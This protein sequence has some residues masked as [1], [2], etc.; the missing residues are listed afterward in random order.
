MVELELYE[1]IGGELLL[2][3]EFLSIEGRVDVYAGANEVDDYQLTVSKRDEA[4]GLE[5]S[6]AAVINHMI[7]EGAFE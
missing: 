1:R 6:M 4:L 2:V 7:G 3:G 5:T